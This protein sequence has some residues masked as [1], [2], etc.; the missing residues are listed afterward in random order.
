MSRKESKFYV[1]NFIDPWIIF[2]FL[3]KKKKL[4][5]RAMKT[6]IQISDK[7]GTLEGRKEMWARTVNGSEQL[8]L[9]YPDFSW[10]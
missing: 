10:I 7:E 6:H 2:F 9:K 3:K 5:P 8:S 1:I 4:I